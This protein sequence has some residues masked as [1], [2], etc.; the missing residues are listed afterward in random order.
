MEL[1]I[2]ADWILDRMTDIQPGD[3]NLGDM[4]LFVYNE[5]EWKWIDLVFEQ[6][7]FFYEVRTYQYTESATVEGWICNVKDFLKMEEAIPGFV[8]KIRRTGLFDKQIAEYIKS[9][10]LKRLMSN[11]NITG[12]NKW[13]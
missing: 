4:I 2:T 3:G 13:K 7:G 6:L 1:R 9:Q 10:K 11:L 8:E 5:S 12:L